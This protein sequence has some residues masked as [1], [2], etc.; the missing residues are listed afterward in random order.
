[1]WTPNTTRRYHDPGQTTV[2]SESIHP[3]TRI[4]TVHLTVADL[5][6]QA[7]FYREV[8]G[9][10]LHWREGDSAGLGAGGDDLLVLNRNAGA[11]PAR[12]ATGLYHFAVLVPN[13]KELARVVARL[14]SLG[15]PQAP[16]DHV[17]TETTYLDDSE[18]NGIEVYADTPEDGVWEIAEGQFFARDAAGVVRSGRDP[19]D[20]EALLRHLGPADPLDAPV[21]AEARI[22]HVHLH[23]GDL[24]RAVGFYHDLLGF[25][26]KGISRR[27]GMAFVSAG[28]YHHHIGLNTWL[29]VGAPPPPPGARGLRYFT[30]VL[31]DE[32]EVEQL[33]ERTR[34]AGVP[35]EA[36]LGG[37]FLRDPSQNGVL[38]VAPRALERRPERRS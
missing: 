21:P 31:P 5:D 23:V 8:L 17:M 9:F 29:G 14:M 6:R 2:Q 12:G 4:G 24:E 20:I 7:S 22:G 37:V 30:I 1:M 27:I 35:A 10:S 19:L 25:E 18:G 36:R 34:R 16:T 11:P 26:L 13:R 38:L 32:D 33:A 15:Y 3:A 28:V